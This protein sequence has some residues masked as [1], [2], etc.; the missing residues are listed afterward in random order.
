MTRRGQPM[1]NKRLDSEEEFEG[2]Y[3]AREMRIVDARRREL[4]WQ[5]RTE[6]FRNNLPIIGIVAIAIAGVALAILLGVN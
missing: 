6:K 5:R 4:R 2:Y 1:T 3:T